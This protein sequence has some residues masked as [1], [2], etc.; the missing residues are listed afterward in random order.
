MSG[1]RSWE[2]ID[3]PLHVLSLG[4]GRQSSVMKPEE[5]PADLFGCDGGACGL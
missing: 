1:L 5:K 2:R 4:V 3:N